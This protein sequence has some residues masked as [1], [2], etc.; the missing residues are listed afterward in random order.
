MLIVGRQVSTP[1]GPLDLLALDTE[2]RLVVIENKRDR[3]PREVLAQAIDYAAY[4]ATM[5]FDDV[6][7]L[8]ESYRLRSGS[9]PTDLA[10]AYE[11]RFGEPLDTI[12]EP[13]RMIIVASRLDD[14]TERMIAFLADVFGVPVNA[15]LPAVRGWID[16]TDMAEA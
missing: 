4:V 11:E 3:T 6:A 10:E 8:F 15:A 1:S 14:S 7:T 5:T 13:P 2:G 12:A 16:R 9:D